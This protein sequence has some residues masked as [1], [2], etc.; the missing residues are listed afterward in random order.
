MRPPQSGWGR[1]GAHQR[2]D[3]GDR[4]RDDERAGAGGDEQH[5]RGVEPALGR[6]GAHGIL[7]EGVEDPGD[8]GEP[9]GDEHDARRVEP[10]EPLR[11]APS[12]RIQTCF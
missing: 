10:G 9:G 7:V 4:R 1:K 3:V 11:C 6:V 8:R 5:E 12:L 2:A